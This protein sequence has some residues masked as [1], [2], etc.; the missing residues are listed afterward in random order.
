MKSNVGQSVTSKFNANIKMNLLVESV[1]SQRG[2]KRRGSRWG[3]ARNAQV[4]TQQVAWYSIK[5][6]KLLIGSSQT[7]VLE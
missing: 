1:R 3:S 7:K 4:V 6:N 5:M 2:K